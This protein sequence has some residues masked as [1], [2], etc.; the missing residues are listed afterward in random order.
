MNNTVRL[1]L[2]VVLSGLGVGTVW[3]DLDNG[4]VASY[5]F[6]GHAQDVSGNGLHATVH[7][8]T[9]VADRLG[10]TNWAYH[11]DGK[12]DYIRIPNMGT[13][14]S[15]ITFAL[16]FKLNSLYPASQSIIAIENASGAY[17]Y[18]PLGIMDRKIIGGFW[19]IGNVIGQT[20]SPKVWY[21]VALTY[22]SFTKTQALYLN[23]ELQGQKMGKL[24]LPR[25]SVFVYLGKRQKSCSFTAASNLCQV[26][27]SYF[28]GV[29]DDVRF[30]NRS[31]PNA[32]IKVLYEKGRKK[33]PCR[34]HVTTKKQPA[35]DNNAIYRI[36][37]KQET[38]C[39]KAENV[40][41]KLALTEKRQGL[42][43]EQN[44]LNFGNIAPQQS[45]QQDAKIMDP[46]T[47]SSQETS[48]SMDFD[49]ECVYSVP[50]KA[51]KNVV[52]EVVED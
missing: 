13:H 43:L 5:P 17:H 48:L 24:S 26:D 44:S 15:S 14:P 50:S 10:N 19:N 37:V 47:T 41:A 51:H 3:A 52:I 16:W 2:A 40:V 21:H 49:Y 45:V 36:T 9:L 7:G 32:Q 23:G 35:Q 12:D 34:L 30:Y 11:F 46:N 20:L 25:W 38:S 28:K 39:C 6:N 27:A 42:T 22:D 31:L 8:A 1:I 18:T 4:L 29:L 33:S